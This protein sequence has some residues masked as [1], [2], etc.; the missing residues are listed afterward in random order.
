MVLIDTILVCLFLI[1]FVVAFSLLFSG[2]PLGKNYHTLKCIIVFGL[3][4]IGATLMIIYEY[5]RSRASKRS[6]SH[7]T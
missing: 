1:H 5:T 6:A 2:E 3:P 7:H 4:V